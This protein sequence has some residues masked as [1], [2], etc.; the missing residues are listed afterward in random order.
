MTVTRRPGDRWGALVG[1]ACALAMAATGLTG[2]AEDPDAGTNGVGRLPAQ[3]IE[4]RTRAAAESA[5]AVRLSGEVSSG[6]RTY[7]LDMRLRS[8]GGMGTVTSG[9]GSF[10]LLRIGDRLFL[11]ADA[12]FWSGDAEAAAAETLGGKYV[13]VPHGDPSY[14]RFLGFADKD[15]LLDGVLALHGSVRTDG[16]RELGGVPT[17][18]VTGDDGAGGSLDVSLEGT[19]YPMRLVRAGGAGTID[20]SEWNRDFP[21]TEP[22]EEEILDYG[23]GLPAS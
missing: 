9:D 4:A 2:C 6:G 10:S 22:D 7:R 20:F 8:Q 17:V 5:S 11:E 3:E 1:A 18:R 14:K 19:P 13:T 16:R 12:E 15:T 21:L 23:G